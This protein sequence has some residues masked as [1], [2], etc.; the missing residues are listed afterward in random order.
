MRP[1]ALGVDAA[2]SAS[3]DSGFAL[4]RRIGA[5]RCRL[6]AAGANLDGFAAA[7]GLELGDRRQA[8]LDGGLALESAAARL[9]G[10]LTAW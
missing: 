1:A 10:V 3:R 2:W 4:V 5:R 8:R 9:G 6:L 7:C